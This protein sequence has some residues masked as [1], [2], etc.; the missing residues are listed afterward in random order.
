VSADLFINERSI[1]SS[2][3]IGGYLLKC[4]KSTA[5]DRHLQREPFLRYVACPTLGA[6]CVQQVR[7]A[8]VNGS[9][10]SP[11]ANDNCPYV[12]FCA[13][14][15]VAKMNNQVVMRALVSI[16]FIVATCTF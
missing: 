15:V 4:E 10:P 14:A 5:G 12:I 11:G 16:M 9:A 1:L 6:G 3:S 7:G 2:S 8:V 13:S